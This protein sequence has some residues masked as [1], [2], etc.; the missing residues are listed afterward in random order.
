MKGVASEQNAAAYEKRIQLLREAVEAYQTYL[1][2]YVYER[3][4]Q[5]QDAENIVQELWR[6]VIVYYKT[7]QIKELPMLRNKARQLFI[8]YYRA[9]QRKPLVLVE[10][11]PEDNVSMG[12]VSP[13]IPTTDASLKAEFFGQ[14]IELDLT[15]SQCD[16]LWLHARFDMTY[17]EISERLNVPVST[18]GGWIA[19]ARK[20]IAKHLN[21]GEQ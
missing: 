3:T 7:D 9:K 13:T 19:K 5:W 10:E 21:G 8:D 20:E 1:V 4:H 6:Y 18:L 11:L 12:E 15:Q 2:R 17:A 14:F 16:A